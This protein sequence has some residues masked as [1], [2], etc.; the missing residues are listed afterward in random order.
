M[1]KPLQKIGRSMGQSQMANFINSNNQSRVFTLKSGKTATFSRQFIPNGEIEAKTFVDAQINGRDQSTLTEES[2]KD[3]TRTISLQQFFP[4]IGR[5][6]DGRI[7]IMDGSRRRAACLFAGT[8]LEI[9]VT[10]E[11]IDVS[12]ARQLAADIQTAKEHNLRELGQRF[13]LM[14]EQGMSKSEIARAEG[15]S[16][17]KVTRAFQAASVPSDIIDVFPVVSELTLPDYQ[18]LLDVAE[19]AKAEGMSVEEIVSQIRQ[20]IQNDAAIATA[21][22]DDQKNR[23]LSFFSA[24]KKQLSKP[25]KSK[26]IVTEKFGQF[27]DRTAYAKRKTHAEKR[28][29]QYEFHRL[30][31]A[32]L[33][34]ID[35][36]IKAVIAKAG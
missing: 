34:E 9:L 20:R 30:S 29:V 19:E 33:D 6:V 18:L 2:V 13:M 5:L 14:Q 36:A 16:N 8:G 3:I 4:A 26:G 28:H 10:E 23:I 25:V 24:A 31:A 22:A 15:I 11:P 21:N 17:A 12:D 1:S 35:A 7:E 27:T 32:M